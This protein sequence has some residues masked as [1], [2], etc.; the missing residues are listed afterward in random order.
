MIKVNRLLSKKGFTLI[1]LLVVIAIIGLL[2]TFI[3]ASFTSAQAKSRDARRKADMDAIKK[4]LELFKNDT[5]GAAKYPNTTTGSLV[6]GNYIRVVPTD[7]S[8]T[9]T[10]YVYTPLTSA[11]GACAGGGDTPVAAS[12]GTCQTYTLVICLEN[13][14]DPNA[15]QPVVACTPPGQA[16][17]SGAVYT[18]RNP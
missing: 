4:A 6:A 1:E 8:S 16:A 12:A 5:S 3:V 13:E 15:N 2:A 9:T 17:N 7:P 14:A 18:V 10:V 11:G